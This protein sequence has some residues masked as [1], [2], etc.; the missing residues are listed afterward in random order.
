[1]LMALQDTKRA[2]HHNQPKKGR[3]FHK[4]LSLDVKDEWLGINSYP[5]IF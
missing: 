4:L 5:P 3:N 1:M 2:R